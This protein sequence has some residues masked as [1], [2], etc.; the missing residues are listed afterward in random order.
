LSY[1]IEALVPRHFEA[2]RQRS[3][4]LI[5]KTKAAVHERLTKEIVYWDH[6][7]AQLARQE[8]TGRT[9]SLNSLQ[10]RRRCDELEARLQ[11]RL[12]ELEQE[13]RLAPLP[14]VAIG[15][16]ADRAERVAGAP[17]GRGPA[18]DGTP[19]LASASASSNWRCRRSWRRNAGWATCPATSAT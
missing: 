7:S 11:Q 10:A 13:R 12:A 4:A 8:Q 18:P 1:A 19:P 16:R 9:A 17:A 3:E 14:P 6:R 5:D 15:G 2:V